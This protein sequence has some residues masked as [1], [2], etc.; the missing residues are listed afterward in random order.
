MLVREGGG[1]AYR[2]WQL[3]DFDTYRNPALLTAAVREVRPT[4]RCNT[5]HPRLDVSARPR[6]VSTGLDRRGPARGQ[7]AASAPLAGG[8]RPSSSR[9]AG[10]RH[11]AG[12]AARVGKVRRVAG[13]AARLPPLLAGALAA[14]AVRQRA[15]AAGCTSALPL[16]LRRGRERTREGPRLGVAWE[17][18]RTDTHI[19]TLR[20]DGSHGLDLS[21]K[22]HLLGASFSSLPGALP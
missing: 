14:G 21:F 15:R 6:L 11:A 19:L 18:R 10:G 2:R 7:Q 3:R 22:T 8:R 5:L 13:A 4:A 20:E 17:E 12:Q 16:G 1:G 9:R